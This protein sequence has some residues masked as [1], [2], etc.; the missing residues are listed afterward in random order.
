MV[1]EVGEQDVEEA[2]VV[3]EEAA[4]REPFLQ[5]FLCS[6]L[7]AGP[8]CG[9]KEAEFPYTPPLRTTLLPQDDCLRLPLAESLGQSHGCFPLS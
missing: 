3:A 7:R 6:S 5:R 9:V 1:D 4:G 2:A 8:Q